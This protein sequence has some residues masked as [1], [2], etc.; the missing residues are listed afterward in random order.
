MQYRTQHHLDTVAKAPPLCYHIHTSG[1]SGTDAGT[2]WVD[3]AAG[4]G[5][6]VDVTVLCNSVRG[7]TEVLREVETRG[8]T[9]AEQQQQLER[10]G[11]EVEARLLA[12]RELG[13][14]ECT[15]REEELEHTIYSQ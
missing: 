5:E 3:W 10:I 4:E 14:A 11:A 6:A 7:G 13:E 1:A 15:A 9:S 8:G 12:Q 2:S